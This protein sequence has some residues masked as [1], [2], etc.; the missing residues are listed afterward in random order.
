[1]PLNAIEKHKLR[2]HIRKRIKESEVNYRPPTP[3]H[4]LP[5]SD[6]KVRDRQTKRDYQNRP[7]PF[8]LN[9]KL[10]IDG[11]LF[12]HLLLLDNRDDKLSALVTGGVKVGQFNAIRVT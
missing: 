12:S 2:V 7:P 11:K 6:S 4:Q 3:R 9:L 5:P 1:M 10:P 8:V